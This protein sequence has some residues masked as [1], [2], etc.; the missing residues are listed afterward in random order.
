MIKKIVAITFSFFLGATV[1]VADSFAQGPTISVKT[2]PGKIRFTTVD[3]HSLYE[4]AGFKSGDVV[5]E[6]NG[7]IID[8]NARLYDIDEV[9]RKG[10]TVKV[11]RKGK[12]KILKIK[13]MEEALP[14]PPTEEFISTPETPSEPASE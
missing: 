9:I 12:P 6:I 1:M 10:G 4:K 11:E 2:R 14:E 3:K 5:R 8:E 7:K 13:A